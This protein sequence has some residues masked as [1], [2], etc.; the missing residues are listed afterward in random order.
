[1]AIIKYDQEDIIPIV[2]TVLNFCNVDLASYGY[3]FVIENELPHLKDLI[4]DEVDISLYFQLLETSD[5]GI[6]KNVLKGNNLIFDAIDILQII[7]GID[8]TDL[9]SD[10]RIR[11]LSED[12]YDNLNGY[13]FNLNKGNDLP[14]IIS[15]SFYDASNA[16]YFLCQLMLHQEL[17]YDRFEKDGLMG[18]GL[19]KVHLIDTSNGNVSIVFDLIEKMWEF[20]EIIMDGKWE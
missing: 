3:R 13:A 20:Q 10:E 4:N 6:P 16:F 17:D 1:M 5:H 19:E 18:A 9:F 7:H 11:D 8:L 14:L 12:L 2:I 15:T